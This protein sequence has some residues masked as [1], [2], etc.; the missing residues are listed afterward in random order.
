MILPRFEMHRPDTLEEAAAL[1]A[2]YGDDA[3]LYCGGTELLLLM[4]LG[5]AEYGHLIDV[6]R[7]PELRAVTVRDGALRIG[8]AVTHRS[9]ETSPQVRS[10]W[11]PLADME[12]GVANLRVRNQGTLGGNLCFS[13]PHSDPATFLLV[14]RA[15]LTSR[16]RGGRER[17]VSI[18]EFGRGP[19]ETLLEPDEVLVSIEVPALPPAASVVHKKY[20]FHERPAATLTCM[21]VVEDGRVSGVRIA[22]GSVGVVPVRATEA[23][24]LLEGMSVDSSLDE[25]AL[26]AAG[27]AAAEAADPVADT[28]GSVEYKKQLIRVL[29]ERCLR[30]SAGRAHANDSA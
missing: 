12:R 23:E 25:E 5:F 21:T 2:E 6:K 13:D 20:S 22:V 9:I 18:E 16:R 24:R 29:L 7:I 15:S 17:N 8:A 3:A 14:A 28:N 26:E 10:V 1:L 11:S 27:V 30:E 4:K 19:F